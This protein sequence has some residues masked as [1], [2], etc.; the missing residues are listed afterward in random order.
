MRTVRKSGEVKAE[1]NPLL[2]FNI[3][4][5]R[6]F[7]FYERAIILTIGNQA[8]RIEFASHEQMQ[9]A[10]EQWLEASGRKS[11]PGNA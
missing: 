9:S 3:E 7:G 2:A 6:M 10:I 8:E 4:D 5:V 1:L 11:E